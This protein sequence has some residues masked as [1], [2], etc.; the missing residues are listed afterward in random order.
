MKYNTNLMAK[1]QKKIH[2][3]INCKDCTEDGI[4]EKMAASFLAMDNNPPPVFD[5][6]PKNEQLPLDPEEAAEECSD[7]NRL[8][9]A[10]DCMYSCFLGTKKKYD[11]E[12]SN[13]QI[14]NLG[15]YVLFPS[16]WYYQVFFKDCGDMI[17]SLLSSL[18]DQVL[19]QIVRDFHT[20]L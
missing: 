14:N 12:I 10:K 20:H 11:H 6:D 19:T 9:V 1:Q 7:N 4:D 18:Q 15:D 17:T 8:N 16:K 2:D 3:K 5:T 13:V